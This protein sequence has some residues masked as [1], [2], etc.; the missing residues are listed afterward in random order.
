MHSGET[1]RCRG[2]RIAPAASYLGD[3]YTDSELSNKATPTG[4]T[5]K[6]GTVSTD[7]FPIE[8]WQE[9]AHPSAQTNLHAGLAL[10]HHPQ[11]APKL[12]A[13]NLSKR[14]PCPSET[15]EDARSSRSW[16]PKRMLACRCQKWFL[17]AKR[18]A[19]G[20]IDFNRVSVSQ[21][22]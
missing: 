12:A 17:L 10:Q 21:V 13:S 20:Q 18:L 7:H 14:L 9:G 16:H 1:S 3:F 11:C 6:E 8:V 22:K 19:T 4:L 5:C 2:V 15:S